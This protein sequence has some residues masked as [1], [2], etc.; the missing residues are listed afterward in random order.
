[1]ALH[2]SW[3]MIHETEDDEEVAFRTR[4]CELG[5]AWEYAERLVLA[6]D[7]ASFNFPHEFTQ[8]YVILATS[9]MQTLHC[10]LLKEN[11]CHRKLDYQ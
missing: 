11:L 6:R 8:D 5:L 1:M 9:K 2:E 7:A 4:R 10:V 3:K